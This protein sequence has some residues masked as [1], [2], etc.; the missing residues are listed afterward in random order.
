ME[1]A[2]VPT[3]Q[4]AQHVDVVGVGMILAV[5]CLSINPGNRHA[6]DT[7]NSV[8]GQPFS[9]LLMGHH[10][11]WRVQRYTEQCKPNEDAADDRHAGGG[12]CG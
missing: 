4:A 3:E 9:L 7:A 12:I 8:S 10:R 6:A 1:D 11:Q 2:S 5:R